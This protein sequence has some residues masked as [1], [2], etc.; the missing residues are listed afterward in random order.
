MVTIIDII[1]SSILAAQWPRPGQRQPHY[2]LLS[3]VLF[4]AEAFPQPFR[5]LVHGLVHSSGHY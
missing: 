4:V 1:I 2:H 5:R 3:G